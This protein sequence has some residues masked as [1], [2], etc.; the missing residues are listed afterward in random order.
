AVG[1]YLVMYMAFAYQLHRW[2]LSAR[3]EPAEGLGVWR[4]IFVELF[5]LRQRHRRRKKKLARIVQE[6]KASTAALPDGAVVIDRHGHIVCFM[7]PAGVLLALRSPQDVGQRIS[8][9]LRAPGVATFIDRG[10]DGIGELEMPAPNND[11]ATILLRL[12]PYGDR[13]RLIIARDIS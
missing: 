2:L 6:F 7:Q 1:L 9:L 12:I 3:N 10:G 13:Q 11:D 4:E 5:R 8:N